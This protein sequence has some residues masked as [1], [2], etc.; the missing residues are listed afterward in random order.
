MIALIEG[1]DP[2]EAESKGLLL[3][4]RDP[5]CGLIGN[6]RFS[7]GETKATSFADAFTIFLSGCRYAGISE[8]NDLLGRFDLHMRKE[9]GTKNWVQRLSDRFPDEE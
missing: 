2:Q 1:Y 9:V 5:V 6:P 4:I 7:F 3:V 8:T